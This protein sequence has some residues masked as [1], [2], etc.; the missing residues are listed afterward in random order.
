MVEKQCSFSAAWQDVVFLRSITTSRFGLFLYRT[1]GVHAR[2]M[3]WCKY[4]SDIDFEA[5]E[6]EEATRPGFL[7]L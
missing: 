7:L 1:R 5:Q 6:P 4:E 2:D 3:N